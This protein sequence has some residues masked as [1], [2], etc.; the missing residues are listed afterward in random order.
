MDHDDLTKITTRHWLTGQVTSW[1]PDDP[2]QL[3]E[4]SIAI[5]GEARRSVAQP[6]RRHSVLHGGGAFIT[7]KV[8]GANVP[9]GI[10]QVLRLSGH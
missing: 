7:P 5:A 4:M 2:H 10:A 8:G 3:S 6:S 1:C 9:E